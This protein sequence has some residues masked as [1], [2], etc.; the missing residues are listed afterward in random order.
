VEEA[1]VNV[2][3]SGHVYDV[4]NVDGDGTQRIAF[5]LRRDPEARVLPAGERDEGILSQEL[6][7]VLIDRTL[8]LNAEAPCAENGE[9]VDA[10]RRCLRLYESRAARRTIEKLPMPELQDVC[11]ECQHVLC[12]HRGEGR[13][14][15]DIDLAGRAGRGEA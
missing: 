4:Q 13:G 15:K 3:V 12:L 14:V 5:V 1:R 10:L 6:L 2:V 8:Y 7:R 11:E 9:I